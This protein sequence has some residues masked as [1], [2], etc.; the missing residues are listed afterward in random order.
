MLEEDKK[1]VNWFDNLMTSEQKSFRREIALAC[2]V[3][4]VTV[5][6]LLGVT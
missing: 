6:T 3:S 1:F 4:R 5:Y 2:D